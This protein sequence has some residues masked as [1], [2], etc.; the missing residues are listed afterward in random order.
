MLPYLSAPPVR[1]GVIVFD[2][3]A[4]LGGIGVLVGHF[5]FLRNAQSFGFERQQA[6]R[7]SLLLMLGGAIGSFLFGLWATGYKLRDWQ[8]LPLSLSSLGAL[9]GA[10]VT[11]ILWSL[12][13]RL[14]FAQSVR[15]LD[16]A[17]LAFP[18]TWIFLRAACILQH[19]HP[20]IRTD[21]WLAVPYP[22]WPRYDLAFLE[23]LFLIPVMIGFELIRK[24]ALP[25]GSFTVILLVLYG[26]MRLWINPLRI[27]PVRY[28]GVSVDQWTV[29]VF[30]GLGI[31]IMS[32]MQF[33]RQGQ[34]TRS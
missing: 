12:W 33:H 13:K 22:D 15:W 19:D 23:F 10:T 7:L 21:S 17:A 8:T 18:V 32:R 25:A 28:L 24:W 16:A 31:F 26:A 14:P 4:I 29:G 27:D 11:A 3:S 5:V 30:A 2:L 6:S 20:G 9:S 1:I 34:G